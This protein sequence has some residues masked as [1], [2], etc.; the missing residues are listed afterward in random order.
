M[1]P[2]PAPARPLPRRPAALLGAAASVVLA[3]VLSGCGVRLESAPP[4]PL[5]PTADEAVRAATVADV[6]AVRD[7]AER[8]LTDGGSAGATGARLRAVVKHAGTQLAALGGVYTGPPPTTSPAATPTTAAA[9]AATAGAVANRLTSASTAGRAR[10]ADAP[11]PHLA[12][13]VAQVSTSQALDARALAAAAH[14]EVAAPKAVRV[15]VPATLP[16]GAHAGTAATVVENEDAA[17]YLLEVVAARSHGTTRTTAAARAAQHRT[18]AQD[19]ADAT[20]ISGTDGDPRRTAYA[21]PAEAVARTVESR[22][23]TSYAALLDTLDPKGRTQV[24][25]LLSDAARAAVDAGAP[26]TALPGGTPK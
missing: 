3:L 12:R 19:W 26:I 11:D 9:S 10:L 5:T 2:H 7:L 8:A 21:V 6:V 20:G 14:V 1:S 13:L 4:A 16:A 25:D 18:R 22:L 17:G 15:A 23:V 24:A